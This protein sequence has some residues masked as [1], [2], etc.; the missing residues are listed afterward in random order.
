MTVTYT[1]E[2]SKAKFWGFPKLLARWKGSIYRL[3]YREMLVFLIAYY[4]ILLVYRY[5]LDV[6]QKRTFEAIALYSREFCSEVMVTFVLG[7]YVTL[8]MGRWWQQYMNIPWPDRISMQ[9]AAY[10]NGTDERSRM[11]RRAMARYLNLLT[12]FTFQNTS[13]VI[14]KRFPT[15]EH[16]VAAGLMTEEEK[17]ELD[18][19]ATPHGV[20]WLPAHWFVQLAVLARRE[21]RIHDDFHLKTLI[22]DVME[23][24][25]MCGMIWSY[26][27]ISVPLVYT[28]VVTIA[29]YS[30]FAASLFGRQYLYNSEAPNS[31]PIV[32]YYV[33]L[34][35]IFQ[36]FFFVG[37]LKVAESMICPFGEDDD[38]FDL[39]WI[40]DRN[41]QIAYQIVDQLHGRTPKLSKDPLWDEAEPTLPYTE[42]SAAFKTEPHVGSTTAM[43]IPEKAAQWEATDVMP[44][45]CEEDG[46]NYYIRKNKDLDDDD[47]GDSDTASQPSRLRRSRQRLPGLMPGYSRQNLASRVGSK[48]GS[49]NSVF[50]VKPPSSPPIPSVRKM[51]ISR[52]RNMDSNMS[53]FSDTLIRDSQLNIESFNTCNV[54]DG[55]AEAVMANAPPVLQMLPTPSEK[56][57]NATALQNVP[58]H[59]V[60]DLTEPEMPRKM[61]IQGVQGVQGIQGP[62]TTFDD[63]N[64]ASEISDSN[65]QT[66][67]CKKSDDE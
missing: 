7:F 39:N 31:F 44:A 27:W 23:F 65:S 2:V 24:R 16:L 46:A 40:I 66:L 5:L 59:G 49:L 53:D 38:D 60:L 19:T 67:L 37:W 4:T 3:I 45:I 1:L 55:D 14:K 51:S 43:N 25:G 54:L 52:A 48:F 42:A 22:D 58:E 35:T 20:W 10:V 64:S 13:T 30:F 29:V 15:M 47:D 36:F 9:I 62:A 8:V 12:L 50:G 41:I 21:C 6:E 61:S 63:H 18:N 11:I 26:D 32:D 17:A 28:Q 33:P 57:Y 56:V 34:F